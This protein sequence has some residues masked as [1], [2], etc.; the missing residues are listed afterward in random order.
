MTVSNFQR[1][2]LTANIFRCNYTVFTDNQYFWRKVFVRLISKTLGNWKT[3]SNWHSYTICTSL[4]LNIFICT[5][6]TVKSSDRK[7]ILIQKQASSPYRPNSIGMHLLP[8]NW[9]ITSSEAMFQSLPRIRLT[10]RNAKRS[11]TWAFDIIKNAVEVSRTDNKNPQVPYLTFSD[12]I[13]AAAS[14]GIGWAHAHSTLANA[15]LGICTISTSFFGGW[16]NESLSWAAPNPTVV[17][18]LDRCAVHY[19]QSTIQYNVR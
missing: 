5:R 12:T 9:S 1:H 13:S 4:I 19:L 10:A 17:T 6:L 11:L 8:I 3:N 2:S 18:G 14:G 7:S 15:G 16:V